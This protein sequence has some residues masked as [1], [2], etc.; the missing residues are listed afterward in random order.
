MPKEESLINSPTVDRI[1][2]ELY[3]VWCQSAGGSGWYSW[4]RLVADKPELAMRWRSAA[5]R[6]IE[7]IGP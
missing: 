7:L 4:K 6:A 5:L 1:A 2:D 3:T